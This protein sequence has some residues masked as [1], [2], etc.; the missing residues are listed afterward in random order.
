VPERE[1]LAQ[2]DGNSI[3]WKDQ[4]NGYDRILGTH[5]PPLQGYSVF[6]VVSKLSLILFI[7]S[8]SRFAL[9]LAPC[10]TLG[11]SRD[12]ADVLYVFVIV[13]AGETF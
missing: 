9:R 1:L 6:T 7:L 12:N 13:R 11:G 2:P 3:R 10:E 8:Q 5:R 4:A